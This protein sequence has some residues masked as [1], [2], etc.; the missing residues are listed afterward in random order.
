M[1]LIDLTKEELIKYIKK[2]ENQIDK[3]E[4]DKEYWRTELIECE[5][6]EIR[7]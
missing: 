5:A 1:N 2:L 6:R 7:N 4:E 3:L